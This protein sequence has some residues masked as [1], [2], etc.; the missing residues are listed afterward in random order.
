M[1][2]HE[3]LITGGELT[4][5]SRKADTEPHAVESVWIPHNCLL[6]L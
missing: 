1:G 2:G 4:V 3:H 6:A 5:E